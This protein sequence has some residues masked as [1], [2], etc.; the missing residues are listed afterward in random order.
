MERHT[1]ILF[2]CRY[3]VS[4]SFLIKLLTTQSAKQVI[5]IQ[6]LA[7]F[8]N[9]DIHHCVSAHNCAQ[10]LRLQV[11][12]SEIQA[13]LLSLLQGCH[14]KADPVLSPQRLNWDMWRKEFHCYNVW[15]I[16]TFSTNL[17][18]IHAF[19]IQSMTSKWAQMAISCSSMETRYQSDLPYLHIPLCHMHMELLI[20]PQSHLH[21]AVI[22][23]Q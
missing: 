19:T 21:C 1:I 15:Q 9:I 17:T 13:P 16:K 7:I 20:L 8:I 22:E 5:I 2:W 6:H 4:F 10:L 18:Y 3:Q 14:D 23:S 11:R 12:R